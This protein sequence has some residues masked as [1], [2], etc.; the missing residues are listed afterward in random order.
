MTNEIQE[1]LR[2]G[3]SINDACAKYGLTFKELCEKM[4]KP[5][6]LLQRKAKKPPRLTGERYIQKWFGCYHIRKS[7]NKKTVSFGS[8]DTLEDA[9]L[10]RD[11]L[12]EHGWRKD[13]LD[14]Y[15]SR[16]GVTRRK[17]R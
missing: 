8:Y 4:P 6:T 7:I 5:Y 17:K 14:V 2:N 15:C 11:Y 16:L 9:V 12:M 10:M 3:M 1:D 13:L